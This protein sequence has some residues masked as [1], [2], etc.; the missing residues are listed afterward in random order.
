MAYTHFARK[1][2]TWDPNRK[3]EQ[4]S[5]S[6]WFAGTKP[7]GLW[8]SVSPNSRANLD[9]HAS[10][11]SRMDLNWLDWPAWC[12]REG[13]CLS[14]L[15]VEH[16]VTLTPSAN[17]LSLTSAEAIDEFTAKYHTNPAMATFDTFALNAGIDWARVTSE[18]DGMIIAPWQPSRHHVYWWYNSWD[19]ASGCIWN[20]AA[21]E[22]FV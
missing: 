3:Y 4:P 19:C 20:L 15:A 14:D 13:F 22:S 11:N 12:E 9:P 8:V 1:R 5:A 16:V 10:S 21:I 17:I 2:V 7:N 6:A 18:Y